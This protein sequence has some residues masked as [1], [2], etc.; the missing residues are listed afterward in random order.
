MMGMTFAVVDDNH[1]SI[2]AP[3]GVGAGMKS[4]S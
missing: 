1:S 4:L 3:A 2:G